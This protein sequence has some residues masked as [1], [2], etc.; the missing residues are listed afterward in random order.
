MDFLSSPGWDVLLSSLSEGPHQR[1]GLCCDAPTIRP[2]M[3]SAPPFFSTRLSSTCED[4]SGLLS[5][6]QLS[7]R[8]WRAL[9]S[10]NIPTGVHS[11][12]PVYCLQCCFGAYL[13]CYG[14]KTINY[15]IHLICMQIVKMYINKENSILCTYLFLLL[16]NIWLT[17]WDSCTSTSFNLTS[18]VWCWYSNFVFGSTVSSY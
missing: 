6:I 17:W 3:T 15:L 16:K 18:P 8:L 12:A 2:E 7:W 1:S 11:H 4:H 9:R 10:S 5:I 14:K 13:H